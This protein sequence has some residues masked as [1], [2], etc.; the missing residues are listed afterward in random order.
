MVNGLTGTLNELCAGLS[1]KIYIE[2]PDDNLSDYSDL[3]VVKIS[4]DD[5]E[6]LVAGGNVNPR[7]IYIISSDVIDAYEQKIIN[8]QD[9]TGQMDA[10]NLRTLNR[11]MSSAKPLSDY[12]NDNGLEEIDWN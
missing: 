8:V 10:V 11:T 12:Y 5:Y 9:A 7:S 4:K 1:T 6:L 2:N 3:S